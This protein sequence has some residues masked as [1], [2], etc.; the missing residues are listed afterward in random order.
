MAETLI[1]PGVLARENDQSQLSPSGPITFGAAII[2]PTVKG[3]VEV[4]TIVTSYNEYAT[5]FGTTFIS[6]GRNVSYLTS[7][8]A[9]NYFNNGGTSLLVARVVSQSSAWT[10]ATSTTIA[11]GIT[12]TPGISASTFYSASN[13]GFNGSPVFRINNGSTNYFFIPTSSGTWVDDTTTTE[14]FYYFASASHQSQSFWNLT[15]KINAVAN[16]GS[17]GFFA[18]TGSK[19]DTSTVLIFSA[20]A[21]W[22]GAIFTTG[23]SNDTTAHSTQA[24]LTGATAAIG[25]NTFTL[26]TQAKGIIMNSSSSESNGILDSG[27]I[28]NFRW[29]I[30]NRNT[31]QGTFDLVIRR[32]DD[33][34]IAPIVLETWTGL[35]LDPLAP[36]FI[37][38]VIGDQYQQLDNT[39]TYLL[40]MCM[41]I[42]YL[43][44]PLIIL[45][46]VE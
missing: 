46:I 32:G 11:N 35:S 42:L 2:G 9:Y 17:S 36:N 10:S 3:P 29:Q 30:S 39:N 28:N 40:N 37:S 15:Q 8:A 43:P 45:I 26:K 23:S 22:N 1:S 34:N 41:L 18:T 44:L 4:P 38:R 16:V 20:S 13:S 25:T 19:T 7:I 12:A 6:G 33:N 31:A 27:S 14:Q 5:K 21:N 24:T